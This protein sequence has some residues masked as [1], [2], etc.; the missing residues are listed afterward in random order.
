MF[1]WKSKRAIA[2]LTLV[3]LISFMMPV[4]GYAAPGSQNAK[5][6]QTKKEDKS[7][8]QSVG[9]DADDPLETNAELEADTVTEDGSDGTG[10][11]L[12]YSVEDL[13]KATRE[14]T[15]ASV[16]AV[17]PEDAGEPLRTMPEHVKTSY[18][19]DIF[20]NRTTLQG[21]FSSNEL[22]FYVPNYWDTKYVYVELQYDVSELVQSVA[23]SITFSINNVPIASY[24][25][26]Y[27]DGGTQICYLE[28]PMELVLEGY[29]SLAINA[30]ARLYD[31]EGCIDDFTNA[32]WLS[33][34][35]SS[36]IQC[37][38]EVMDAKHM[39]SYY[40]YPFMS[41]VQD[42]GKG[43]SII[44][45]DQATNGEIAAAMNLMA[46]MSTETGKENEI[47]FC[48]L[49]D[50]PSTNANRTILIAGY[51]NLPASYQAKVAE[52]SSL[53]AAASV[54]FTDDEKGNPLLIITSQNDDC[55]T[56]AVYMLMDENRVTQE[57]S[58][59]AIVKM[60]SAQVAIDSTSLSKMVAGNYTVGDIIG[61]GLT[62]V[63]P[64]HQEQYIYL[65]F[66]EDYFLS[67][68]GKVTLNF[69]YSENLDFSRSMISIYWGDVPVASKKLEKEKAGGDEL[70][71]AMP[72][73][74]VGTSAG[75]IRIAFDLEIEDMVC[76]PRQEQMPW[77]YISDESVLFLPAST[78]I[79]LTFDLKPSPF[80]TDGK[81]ND[82]MIVVPDDPSSEELNLY[83]QIIGMYG[84]GV[85]PYGTLYV[86]RASE[87]K[88]EDS[89]YN[90]ITVGTYARNT[91][92]AKLNP[93]LYFPYEENGARFVSNEQLILSEQYAEQIAIL[94][95]LESPYASNRGVLAVT[96][97]TADSLRKVEEFM[98][99]S[100]LRYSLT[101]DCVVIDRDLD[102]K[103]FKFI[104][105]KTD[106]EEPGMMGTLIQNKQSLL[107]T[108]VSTSVM[109]M[110]LIAVI[111]ILIR[112]RMYHRVGNDNNS[113]QEEDE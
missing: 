3:M 19:Q 51:D 77:A 57:K 17:N 7:S 43:L 83:A 42:T 112:I 81:F 30:Y 38:Y 18:K 70:T 10:V 6:T 98:R 36:Y 56:E 28:V 102:I 23:S 27:E 94:Q 16:L 26:A 75:A 85:A 46:D 52:V 44:V 1:T 12:E 55:L 82:M 25:I 73:D 49:S 113:N 32:N 13:E 101:K 58:S 33:I 41:T 100:K 47:Q 86:K 48:K 71:F 8:S 4:V 59:S 2:G 69:R 106:A 66:S 72:A 97:A 68:A 84:D 40:P 74:V 15:I 93:Y 29:N 24:R 88:E 11:N 80:R 78:G 109:L 65:P 87:F 9:F 79:V 45:S 22:Y 62:F 105:E 20:Y 67:D 89:D 95:L 99:D 39:I 61:S 92:M 91:M 34:S 14:D 54:T 111:I 64:F 108:V 104:T 53:N 37:G 110:M 96:G 35:D 107:F 60:G 50:L 63:G 76:T 5:N 31:E 21:I 103:A 90:I